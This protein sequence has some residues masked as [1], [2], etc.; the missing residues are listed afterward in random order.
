M[1]GRKMCEGKPGLLGLRGGKYTEANKENEG[2]DSWFRLQKRKGPVVDL[3][4][5][6]GVQNLVKNAVLR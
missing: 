1:N 3:A 2:D 4:R 6:E 5:I